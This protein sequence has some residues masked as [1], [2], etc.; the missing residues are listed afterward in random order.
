MIAL[1]IETRRRLGPVLH[2]RARTPL[3]TMVRRNPI[4]LL[5]LTLFAVVQNADVVAVAHYFPS[6]VSGAYA[7]AAVAAKGSIWIAVGLGMYLLPEA[8]REASEGKDTRHLLLRTGALLSLVA[9][10]M[11]LV[12][13]VA[14]DQVLNLI[15]GDKASLAA[16]ALPW[17][18]AAM[19]LLSFTYLT[20]QFALALGHRWFVLI[21]AAAA[22]GVPVCVALGHSSLR[23]VAISLLVLNA[24]FA[25]I[26]LGL[27]LRRPSLTA[28]PHPLS[29]EDAEALAV[30]EGAA[31]TEAALG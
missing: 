24:I 19:G 9:V 20:V 10:P 15:F 4:P 31:A 22:V 6:S 5:A 8:A 23:T 17:L 11:V 25:A 14:G 28:A 12:Y 18:G 3:R 1:A 16:A 13:A 2:D 29:A 30:A 27:S 21:I 7:Q 26:M